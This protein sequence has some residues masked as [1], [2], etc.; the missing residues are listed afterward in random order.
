MLIYDAAEQA[1]LSWVHA[2]PDGYVLNAPKSDG[3]DLHYAMLHRATCR[4][5]SSDQRTNYTTTSY[6][7]VCSLKK[8]ELVD[9]G[10]KHSSNFKECLLCKP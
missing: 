6:N 1:Y 2:H 10:R 9:W 8:Q 5:I 3:S 7:K 4:S